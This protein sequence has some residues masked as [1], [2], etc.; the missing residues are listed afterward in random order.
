[1]QRSRDKEDPIQVNKENEEEDEQRNYDGCEA[2]QHLTNPVKRQKEKKQM[3][4][5]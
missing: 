4:S 3:H 1:M 5:E 2:M